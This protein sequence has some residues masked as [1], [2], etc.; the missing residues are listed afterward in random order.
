MTD[1]ELIDLVEDAIESLV[2][3][4]RVLGSRADGECLHENSVDLATFSNPDG[5][6]CPDCGVQG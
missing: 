6:M 5:F 2:R 1:K 3:V 4:R